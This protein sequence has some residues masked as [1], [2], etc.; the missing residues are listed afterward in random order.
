MIQF[1]FEGWEISVIAF[2][3]HCEFGCMQIKTRKLGPDKG[4]C[5]AL[6]MLSHFGMCRQGVT[7]FQN[8][9]FGFNPEFMGKNGEGIQKQKEK[10]YDF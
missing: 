1:L 2:N 4:T 8:P 10:S 7:F 3:R 5:I 9:T 6:K